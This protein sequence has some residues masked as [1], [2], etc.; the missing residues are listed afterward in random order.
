M[1][2]DYPYRPR[3]NYDGYESTN[4]YSALLLRYVYVFAIGF[5][6]R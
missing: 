5:K 2:C 3:M 4:P 1:L 6:L